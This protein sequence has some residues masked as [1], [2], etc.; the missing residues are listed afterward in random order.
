MIIY[1]WYSSRRDCRTDSRKTREVLAADSKA[2]VL[3]TIG[4][5]CSPNP[6]GFDVRGA[7]TPEETAVALAAP[8]VIF[9]RPAAAG[10]G[11]WWQGT[12]GS[13]VQWRSEGEV[14]RW[15]ANPRPLTARDPE[16]F[17]LNIDTRPKALVEHVVQLLRDAPPARLRIVAG[18][19]RE[20]LRQDRLHPF[21][22]ARPDGTGTPMQRLACELSRDGYERAVKEGRVTWWHALKEEVDEA[23]AED[24]PDKLSTE[25]LQVLSLAGKWLEAL[26]ARGVEVKLP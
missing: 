7:A 1:T 9:W 17:E 26:A 22:P 10:F 15:L 23:F 14:T 24:A 20:R 13:R 21:D 11:E 8:G 16:W 3:R 12:D 6:S 25:L 5:T 19:L 18:F 2:D 4:E